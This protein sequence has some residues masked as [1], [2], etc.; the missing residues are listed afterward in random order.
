[1]DEGV[2]LCCFGMRRE[3]GKFSDLTYWK[4]QRSKFVWLRKTFVS[5]NRDKSGG[6]KDAI[7]AS[8]LHVL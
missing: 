4:K 8:V 2:E 3:N 6:L 1:M 7:E 5:C